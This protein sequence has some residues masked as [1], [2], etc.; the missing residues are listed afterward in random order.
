MEEKVWGDNFIEFIMTANQSS[1]IF[2]IT[3]TIVLLVFKLTG[4][5]AA[6]WVWVF[7]PLITR[8]ALALLVFAIS[9]IVGLIGGIVE[10]FR[11]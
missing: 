5:F 10:R 9:V 8:V 1:F 7:V 2:A 3:L 6:S 4:V 11:Q